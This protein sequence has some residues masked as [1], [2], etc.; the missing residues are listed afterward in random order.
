MFPVDFRSDWTYFF[1]L[2][3]SLGPLHSY[4]MQ[5]QTMTGNSGWSGLC[6]KSASTKCTN[7][8]DI[9]EW[10]GVL[11]IRGFFFYYHY[12]FLYSDFEICV[13]DIKNVQNTRVIERK[14]N[15][16]EGPDSHLLVLNKCRLFSLFSF[17]AISVHNS[18]RSI[19][20]IRWSSH[21]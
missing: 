20:C 16:L 2:L 21:W 17:Y 4:F 12:H 9:N 5:N 6:R 8:R 10:N 19:P 15:G 18:Y 1:R 3:I 14:S 7:G 11:N 13:S